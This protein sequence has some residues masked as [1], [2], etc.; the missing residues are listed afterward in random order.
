MSFK[1]NGP[2]QI[3]VTNAYHGTVEFE[4]DIAQEHTVRR[5][6]L[7]D[8]KVFHQLKIAEPT[9]DITRRH[10]RKHGRPRRLARCSIDRTLRHRRIN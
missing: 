8:T 6:S 2:S 10:Y 4:L 7:Q 5:L 1:V 3:R 9:Q